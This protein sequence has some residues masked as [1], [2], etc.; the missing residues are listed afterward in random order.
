MYKTSHA[1]PTTLELTKAVLKLSCSLQSLNLPH[2]LIG[3]SAIFLLAQAF[4]LPCLLPT[5]ITILIQ[6][7]AELS[8]S[9]LINILSDESADH[10]SGFLTKYRNGIEYPFVTVKR[11]ADDVRGDLLV[12]FSIVDHWGCHEK[13]EAYDFRLPR[14]ET[15][16]IVMPGGERI[17]LINPEW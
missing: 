4:S 1:F 12:E 7:S 3:P 13:R 2:A 9:S 17:P 14:N 6:P 16:S 8:S 10:H 5:N 15:L 11:P